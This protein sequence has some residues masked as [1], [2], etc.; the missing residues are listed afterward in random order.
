[1][2]LAPPRVRRNPDAKPTNRC[3]WLT[4]HDE[5]QEHFHRLGNITLKGVKKSSNGSGATPA[6]S[7]ARPHGTSTNKKS[8]YPSASARIETRGLL[9][10]VSARGTLTNA[11]DESTRT[12]SRSPTRRPPVARTV[13][14]VHSLKHGKSVVRIDWGSTKR[15]PS[16][17]ETGSYESKSLERKD[18]ARRLMRAQEPGHLM[19][20]PRS[21]L[22]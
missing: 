3:L 20:L 13:I 5:H 11:H 6:G 7:L 22:T 14:N 18:A 19:R 8:L 17:T 1:M 16:N 4:F 21:H 12:K 2:A 15:R 10:R 9:S